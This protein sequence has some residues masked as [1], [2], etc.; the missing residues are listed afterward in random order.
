VEYPPNHCLTHSPHTADVTATDAPVK[1]V[2]TLLVQ[3]STPA[4]RNPDTEKIAQL[5]EGVYFH[6]HEKDFSVK[7]NH[8]NLLMCLLY[9]RDFREGGLAENF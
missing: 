5:E 4:P 1:E 8:G 9:F 2:S 7:I 6:P 3:A